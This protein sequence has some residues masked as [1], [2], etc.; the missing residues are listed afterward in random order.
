MGLHLIVSALMRVRRHTA[1]QIKAIRDQGNT[2]A[3]IQSM[4][5]DEPLNAPLSLRDVNITS[6]C[7]SR[8]VTRRTVN[9]HC[10]DT[11]HV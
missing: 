2:L 6:S 9:S 7:S 4:S 1:A 10:S 11:R 3:P 8:P 5:Q